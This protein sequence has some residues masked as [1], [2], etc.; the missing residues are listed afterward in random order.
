[1]SHTVENS[2]NRIVITGTTE[3]GRSAIVSDGPGTVRYPSPYVTSTL[4]WEAESLPVKYS[5]EVVAPAER[6]LPVRGGLRVFIT[7]VAPD[8]ALEELPD[9]KGDAVEAAG[10]SDGGGD[11]PA[12]FHQTPTVD[13][14]TVVA[15]EIWALMDEGEVLLKPG[16]TLIQN[17]TPHS[18]ANRSSETAVLLGVMVAS[19][20]ADV[21]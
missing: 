12:G 6:Y 20:E 7:A 14:I 4:L 17:G 21:G 18:W 15:G 19:D 10:L 16:D 9:A 3:A 5:A 2:H 8:E 1:M 11:R 13:L